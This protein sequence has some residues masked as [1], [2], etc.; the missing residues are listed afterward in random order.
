VDNP[1]RDHLRLERA[2]PPTVIVI[3]GATGDLTRR[4]L[5]PA[6]YSL[7]RSRRLPPQFGIVGIGRG[8]L[9]D[10]AFRE[11]MKEAV[12]GADVELESDVWSSLAANIRYLGGDLA[13]RDLY[14]KLRETLDSE[15]EP[16]A[17]LFY[18]AIPPSAYEDAVRNLGESGLASSPSADAQR[19]IIVEKPFG[20]DLESARGLNTLL[21]E[22][23]DESRIF[24]IDHYLGKETVQN[25][26]V[27]RFGNGMF[28]PI[29][30]RRYIDHV[31]ITAAET[32][33][34]GSRA[35]YYEEAGALRDMVQNH[36]MQL[37]SLVAMEPPQ[38][39]S[40]ETI[41]DRKVDAIVAVQPVVADGAAASA[42]RAQYAAGWSG[43]AEVPGYLDEPGVARESVS[44]TYVA[45]RL[46]LDTWRWAG[47]PFYLRTGKRLP[48][49]ATEIAIEFKKPPLLLF[50]HTPVDDVEPNLLVVKV[51]PDEGISL[52]FQ[53]KLP[54]RKLQI[55][56]VMMD[57]RYHAAFGGR[58]P[59]AYE[60][61]LVD[62]MLGDTS[63]FARHDMVE[64][65][66]EL[67][68]P[69]HRAWQAEGAKRLPT[70]EA[71]EWGPAEADAL[72]EADG[73][74]WR[75]L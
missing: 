55:A 56:P 7:A 65:S 70:Y 14:R 31:Q 25:L 22:W 39:F 68:T 20:H 32:V 64:A 19:R 30:N 4:K 23:F 47:V 17:V 33:G 15:R 43:G 34:V 69:V 71:G 10:E 36:L 73:R 35:A 54:G 51:Q 75:R 72:M 8:A 29:W 3:F 24:R 74:H 60:T 6:L 12:S 26:L 1:L 40:S 37:L 53:A 41:R 59:E 28:E 52:R 16:R 21:H 49:R 42:I 9:S 50:R 45:L 66:W 61:L 18:L 11:R 27:F 48:K 13:D 62:A 38:N 44:E 46:Q 2:P 58:V 63:L 57:F 67:I 5:M